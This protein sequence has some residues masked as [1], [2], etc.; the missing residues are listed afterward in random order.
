M[1][2]HCSRCNGTVCISCRQL[3][4]ISINGRN[5]LCAICG[6]SWVLK[7]ETIPSST[8]VATLDH[9]WKHGK[10]L[11]NWYDT[12]KNNHPKEL[13]A[14]IEFLEGLMDLDVLNQA[15]FSYAICRAAGEKL[16]I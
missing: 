15:R 13:D 9:V 5:D 2:A 10:L 14:S 11:I 12:N 4:P 3:A 6:H 8:A 7:P 16:I 1:L